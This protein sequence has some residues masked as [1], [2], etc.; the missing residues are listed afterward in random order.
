[1]ARKIL[2]KWL[3]SGKICTTYTANPSKKIVTI[4]RQSPKL[5][6]LGFAKI[7]VTTPISGGERMASW[8]VTPGHSWL[9]LSPAELKRIPECARRADYEEDCE[10]SLAVVALPELASNPRLFEG[11]DPAAILERA[12]MICRDWYPDIYEELTGEKA[13]VDNSRKRQQQNFDQVNA[14]KYVVISASPSEEPGK[15]LCFATLGGQRKGVV[16]KWFLVDKD[17]YHARGEFGYVITDEF[18]IQK[19]VA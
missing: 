1:V 19:G 15:V 4:F 17:K 12:M 11:G 8:T 7:L 10:W 6:T 2:C 16:G 9:K 3:I 14:V 18:E 13:T 5:P